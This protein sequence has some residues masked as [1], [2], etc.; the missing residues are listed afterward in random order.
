[1][2]MPRMRL[3]VRRLMGVVAVVAA[4]MGILVPLLKAID[5]A[6]HG[7]YTMALNQRCQDLADR[8]GLAGSPESDVV[9]VL[10]EPTSVWRYWSGTDL[11]GHPAAGA[12]SITTYNYGLSSLVA[13]GLFQVHCVGG[14]V[15]STEQLDD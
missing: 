10:G 1:M 2:P 3:E 14:V 7:P 6:S 8:A 11:T 4:I 12:Y 15:K 9:K 5:A 13:C